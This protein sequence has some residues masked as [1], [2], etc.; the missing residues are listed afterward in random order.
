MVGRKLQGALN[1]VLEQGEGVAFASF[2]Q[3]KQGS[4]AKRLAKDLAVSMVASAALSATGFGLMRNTTPRL[5]WI[6]VTQ[7]RVLMFERPNGHNSVGELVLACPLHALTLT[8]KAGLRS[9]IVV[10]DA[11]SGDTLVRLNFG[12]RKNGA[13]RIAAAARGPRAD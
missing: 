11:G 9:E 1:D 13:L 4:G 10:D 7:G 12:L 3:V 5:I 6:V 2:A 8:L